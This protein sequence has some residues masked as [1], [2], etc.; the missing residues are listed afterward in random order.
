[1][2]SIM[3]LHWQASIRRDPR[4]VNIPYWPHRIIVIGWG[5][6]GRD[7][8]FHPHQICCYRM[9]LQHCCERARCL[10]R[11]TSPEA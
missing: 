4:F 7:A 5:R 10:D 2:V 8:T 6:L 3:G 1:M 11:A 9:N